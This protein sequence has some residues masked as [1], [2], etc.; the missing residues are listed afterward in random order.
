M[1][2]LIV[3]SV[4]RAQGSDVDE[5]QES[6]TGAWTTFLESLPRVGIAIGVLLAFVVTGR[7]LRPLVRRRLVR[8][9]T[10]SF[11]RVFAKLTSSAMTVVGVLLG[12][13]IVFP[14]VRPVDVLSGAGVL[15]IA[16]GFA[17]QDILQNLLAG[18][19]LLFRQP[20]RG[21]DQIKVGDVTGTVEE[22]N[23]RETVIVTFDGRRILIPNAKVYTDVIHVQT[24]HETI[25]TNFVVGIAYEADMAAAR[26]I[27]TEAVSRV[28]G[29]VADPPPEAL[30]VELESSTVNLDIR[31][32]SD[33]HQ[34]ETRRTLD[35]A[36][37]AVKTA[38]DAHGIEM[39]S[40]VIALQA[41]SSLAAALRGGEVTPG[42][43]VANGQASPTHRPDRSTPS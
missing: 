43:S 24:A 25:R 10:P 29:V 2:A 34:L 38:F 15:T 37:E 35:R 12:L 31:F 21:G 6:A 33:A 13:T 39:P 42:G 14:S 30:Y 1:R 41:T 32:W 11:A 18:I 28:A 9:R 20:F 5:L 19:L 22:I 40:Q 26:S 17:F 7:L 27:A 8:H 36:I 23:I 4:L 3:A 16:A